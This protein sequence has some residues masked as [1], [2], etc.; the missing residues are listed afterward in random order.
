[1][2]KRDSM[3]PSRLMSLVLSSA[4]L[5]VVV[6]VLVVGAAWTRAERSQ[7]QL[8]RA[9]ALERDAER[10]D[11]S[12]QAWLL[13]RDRSQISDTVLRQGARRNMTV[14]D[15]IVER[16]I[17][18]VPD[19]VAAA[20]LQRLRDRIRLGAAQPADSRDWRTQSPLI[21]SQL[22]AVR[23]R[24]DAQ[25]QSAKARN[26]S[27][28]QLFR[29]TAF[30]GAA[31]CALLLIGLWIWG[32]RRLPATPRVSGDETVARLVDE[33]VQSRTADLLRQIRVLK[34]AEATAAAARDQAEA[35]NSARAALVANLSHDIRTPLNGILGLTELMLQD[36]P[37]DRDRQRMQTIM[38]SGR[39]LLR[40][41]DGVLTSAVD[42]TAPRAQRPAAGPENAVRLSASVLLA[43]DN[44]INQIVIRE[45][46]EHLGCRVDLAENGRIAVEQSELKAY[47]L[48]LMD[49]HMPE[50]DGIEA[51]KRI[52]AR[53][54]DDGRA[55][56]PIVA[57][58]ANVSDQDADACRRAGMDD[59]VAKPA[60]IE[61]LRRAVARAMELRG[62]AA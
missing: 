26:A 30:F 47:D 25:V 11:D 10:L 41:V 2:R 57:L 14:A 55:H 56:L 5:A 40:V 13:L 8:E 4:L 12:V 38:G 29:Q 3:T 17:V 60:S 39:M 22:E 50:L 45:M 19:S 7:R 33:Q 37:R 16:L 23:R 9:A 44:A 24:I 58:T 36:S 49:W 6:L 59:F 46:L 42:T 18:A 51:T 52:R 15:S 61:T 27:D 21:V 1:M 34:A 48:I 62:E 53:E 32:H 43:E 28:R 31:G 20:E 35:E 54:R